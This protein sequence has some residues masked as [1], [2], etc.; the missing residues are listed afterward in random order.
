MLLTNHH[1]LNSL[2][3]AENA[4]CIFDYEADASGQ[5]RPTTTFRLRPSRLFLTSPSTDGLDFSF[6]WVDGTA[7]RNVWTYRSRA[8][9]AIDRSQDEFA[10]VISHPGGDPKAVTIQDNQV[11]WQNELLVHYTS[12]TLPGSSAQRCSTMNGRYSLCTTPASPRPV[13]RLSTF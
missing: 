8:Q 3:V 11:K 5:I 2:A 13:P 10:N 7:G 9:R 4:V 12:D 6:A 1:V